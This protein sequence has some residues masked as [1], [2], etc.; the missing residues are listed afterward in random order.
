MSNEIDR[1]I[2][3]ASDT[4][5]VAEALVTHMPKVV[6][7]DSVSVTF[8]DSHSEQTSATTFLSPGNGKEQLRVLSPM[9]PQEE[10][11][12]RSNR[13]GIAIDI[14]AEIPSYAQ[15]LVDQGM[16]SI[17]VLPLFVKDSLSG[18]LGLGHRESPMLSEEDLIHER[19]VADQV[20]VALSNA[21]LT[22]EQHKL[23]DLFERYVSPEVATEIWQRREEI[24]LVGEEKTGTV[25]FS[26]IRGFSSRWAGRPSQ[27]ALAWLNHYL[28][29][30]SEIV[31]SNGGF[32]NKFLGDGL[33]VLFGVPLSHSIDQEAVK[34]VRTALDMLAWVKQENAG[35]EDG[36]D[37]LRIG[38]G[39]HTGTLTA[40]NVGAETRMEYSVI[41]ENVNMAARLE[42]LTKRLP[43]DLILSAETQQ[44]V[45]GHFEVEPL[46]EVVVRGFQGK[47]QLYTV[48]QEA[49]VKAVKRESA[50]VSER[51]SRYS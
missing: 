1:A 38:I 31:M 47:S 32:V 45:Q 29:A 42:E 36:E 17:S 3:L 48:N 30:M 41:G 25:L 11:V 51:E 43:A 16:Q 22:Q 12:L 2:L 18:M 28:T 46:A 40:G 50:P 9:T 5:K 19:Q 37:L 7:C 26:D 15:P 33:M 14:G 10:E 23:M 20:S 4:E 6:G 21:H 8:L 49:E 44:L 35:R 34:A 27:E 13:E 39:V 24:S